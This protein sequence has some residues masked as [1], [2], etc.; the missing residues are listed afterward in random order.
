MSKYSNSK[1][2]KCLQK[3]NFDW[4]FFELLKEPHLE[5]GNVFTWNI[6]GEDSENY[7]VSFIFDKNPKTVLMGA[8]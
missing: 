7:K 6:K 3:I 4:S 8:R 5:D 1:S 2:Y